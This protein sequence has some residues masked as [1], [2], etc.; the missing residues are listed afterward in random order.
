MDFSGRLIPRARAKSR[1]ERTK[2]GILLEADL[3]QIFM[4]LT[5]SSLVYSQDVAFSSCLLQVWQ[6][7]SLRWSVIYLE[8]ERNLAGNETVY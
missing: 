2:M 8:I 4:R 6:H 5:Q 1:V 7:W 3:L